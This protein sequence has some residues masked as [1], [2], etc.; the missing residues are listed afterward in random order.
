VLATCLNEGDGDERTGHEKINS[1]V[2]YDC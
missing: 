2:Q 1:E